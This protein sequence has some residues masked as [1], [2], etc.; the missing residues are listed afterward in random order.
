MGRFNCIGDKCGTIDYQEFRGGGVQWQYP[1]ETLQEYLGADNYSTEVIDNFSANTNYRF[2][3]RVIPTANLSTGVWGNESLVSPGFVSNGIVSWNLRVVWRQ[4]SFSRFPPTARFFTG[5]SQPYSTLSINDR[6]ADFYLSYTNNLGTV[7]ERFLGTSTGVWVTRIEATNPALRFTQ[8]IF[9]VFKDNQVV[10]QRTASVCPSAEIIPCVLSDELKKITINKTPYL[11]AISVLP[12]GIHAVKIQG[13]PFPLQQQYP[14]PANC[15]NV[16]RDEIFDIIPNDDPNDPVAG[17]FIAQ[18][19][20]SV[21]CPPPQYQI[22][23]K[24]NDCENCPPGTCPVK[25]GDKV[26]CYDDY[27]K[28]IRE[29]PIEDYCGGI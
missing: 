19:C 17:D 24:C 16:Y 26:C 21:G 12:Y 18:I 28:S 4:S 15:L 20:S 27:G 7:T 25:C 1:G 3:R 23:C 11:S 9:K 8:C 5:E 10:Y 29:I 6:Q 13:F 22:I 2:Y 14:I